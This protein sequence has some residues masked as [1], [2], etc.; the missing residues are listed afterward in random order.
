MPDDRPSRP[1]I[2]LRRG[3]DKRI[4]LGHPWVYANEIDMAAVKALAPGSLVDLADAADRALGVAMVNAR[5]LIA[6]RLITTDA[7]TAIDAEFIGARLR[8]A[9]DI[10]QRLYDA[11]YYR[12]IHAEGDGLPGLIVDRFGDTVC[13]QANTAG[14]D[15]LLPDIAAALE[16]VLAPT[17]IMLRNDSGGR[18]AEGL[19][20][21]TRWL[22]GETSGPL[23]MVE[24]GVRFLADPGHG[25]KTG[26]YF[27]QRPGRSLVGGIAARAR[28]LDLYCH[29]GGF[30]VR[31]A[32]AGA[33]AVVAVESSKPM[34][35]LAQE[36]AARNGFGETCEF[37]AAEVFA[38][39]ER[40]AGTDSR[41]DIVV[42]DPPSFVK[43]KKNLGVG[44]RGYRKLARLSAS[45][46]APD[47]FLFIASCS[48]NL[49]RER[50]GEE[51][52]RGLN[53]AGRGARILAT[54]GAGPDHPA[55][56][57][58]PETR[59]LKTLLL[60]LD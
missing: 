2:R 52:W 19:D 26:W 50:F 22:K 31:A 42:A 27:D 18:A 48:Y 51:V 60:A 56:P 25:Q 41:F 9:L 13:I 35:A 32:A 1:R 47:G 43:S 37:V 38:E 29:S 14:M 7:T 21:E 12:L 10:R 15:R 17:A 11:P 58:I 34:L 45:L 16:L 40:L 44:A 39:A 24:D 46:V 6:A 53:D 4:R 20:T 57:A 54:G 36:A 3:H 28:V 5:S 33:E 59:Y 49:T 30:A 8:R 55:H 23:E